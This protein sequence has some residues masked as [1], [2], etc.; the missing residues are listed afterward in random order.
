MNWEYVIVFP[1]VSLAATV[2]AE[3][4]VLLFSFT[5]VRVWGLIVGATLLVTLILTGKYVIEDGSS[6]LS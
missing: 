4:P 3:T 6:P 2:P 5:P 1:S